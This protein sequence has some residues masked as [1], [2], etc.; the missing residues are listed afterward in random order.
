MSHKSGKAGATRPCNLLGLGILVTRPAHQADP[1]CDLIAEA[2]GRPIRCPPLEIDG[3][4]DPQ[5]AKARLA[6]AGDY[7]LLIFVSANAV[8]HS[9]DL[10]PDDLPADQQVAAIGSAT[11]KALTDC[12]LD[13]TLVPAEQFDSEGLLALPELQ[14]MTGKRVLIL[15]GNGGRELLADSLRE[16]GAEVDY[17][18]V[19]Q[20]LL[21]QRSAQNLIRGWDKMVDIVSVTSRDILDNLFTLLGEEGAE[22]LQNTPLIV[23]SERLAEHARTRGCRHLHLAAGATDPALLDAM[24]ELADDYD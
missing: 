23:V 14:D 3:P 17:A 15:R 7:P 20:R 16:R 12:G 11:A 6:R 10:L 22:L 4:A 13:P 21:P 19:Y 1:L 18:E 24:C 2:H 8:Q 9:F 5:A